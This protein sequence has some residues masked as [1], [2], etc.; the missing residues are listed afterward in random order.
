V[1]RR[2][3]PTLAITNVQALLTPRTETA[4]KGADRDVGQVEIDSDLCEGLPVEVSAANLLAGG[5]WD[6]AGHE[7]ASRFIEGEHPRILPMPKPRG[8]NFMSRL[9]V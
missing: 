8:Y 5:E 2:G 7:W 9:G 4:P 3:P 6:G 1:L